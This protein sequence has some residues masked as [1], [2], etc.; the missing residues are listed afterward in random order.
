MRI[1]FAGLLSLR[2]PPTRLRWLLWGVA[3]IAVDASL[4][5][6]IYGGY[7][8]ALGQKLVYIENAAFHQIEIQPRIDLSE[9][10]SRV[11]SASGLGLPLPAPAK[12]TKRAEAGG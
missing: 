1:F 8:Q 10:Q 11:S 4:G 2:L 12:Q 9:R 3:L 6:W 5:L 7:T